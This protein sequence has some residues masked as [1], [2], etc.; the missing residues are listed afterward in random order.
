MIIGLIKDGKWIIIEVYT[1]PAL[2]PFA[3]EGQ[4]A[5]IIGTVIFE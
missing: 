5:D 4:K 1:L 3:D 2:A